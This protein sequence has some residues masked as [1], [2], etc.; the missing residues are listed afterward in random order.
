MRTVSAIILGAAI[1][2]VLLGHGTTPASGIGA[3][4]SPIQGTPVTS[5]A[6]STTTT[7]PGN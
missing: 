5:S 7:S 4:A 2:F 6:T 1:V 3:P